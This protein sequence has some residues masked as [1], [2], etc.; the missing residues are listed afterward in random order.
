[1]LVAAAALLLLPALPAVAETPGTSQARPANRPVRKAT[2]RAGRASAGAQ[3]KKKLRADLGQVRPDRSPLKAKVAT[4]D[5]A[6]ATKKGKLGRADIS[7]L[8]LSEQIALQIEELLRGPLRGGTTSLFVA[9]AMT[10]KPVFSVYPDDPLNPASNVKLIATATALDLLGP[11]YRYTTRVLGTTPDEQT[12]A[13]AEGLYLLGTYDPTFGKASVEGLARQLVDSGLRTLDGDIV[14]G[15]TPTRD[16]MYRSFVDLR[17][18]AGAP[19]EAPTIVMEPQTDFVKLVVTATTSK[20]KKRVRPGISVTS[21]YVTDE[22][23]HKRIQITVAGQ[24]AAG[25]SV[26]RDVWM[27][28]RAYFAAHLLR[29]ALRDL[30]VEVNGDVRVAELRDYL[31]Q[32]LVAG[33]I[34]VPIAEHRSQR[35]A[36]IVQRV[37]KRSTNWLADRVIMTAAA[38]RY[39]GKPDMKTAV[40]AMYKWL[41]KKA[42]LGREDVVIDTGSGLSYKTELSARQVVAV[43]RAG[44]GLE[45]ATLLR[46]QPVQDAYRRSL[47][48]GGVDGTIRKRFKTLDATVLGKTGTLA[49]VVSIAGVIDVDGRQ[50]VF[51]L[52]TNGHAPHWKGRVRDGHERLVGL[53]CEYLHK[54]PPEDSGLPAVAGDPVPAEPVH[55]ETPSIADEIELLDSDDEESTTESAD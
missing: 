40:E 52:I 46:D 43:L 39:G 9:D 48:I 49:R 30:G 53:L 5:Q 45:E 50:L 35:L 34:P 24:I 19:G 4:G 16:G 32:A 37:N 42:G 26:V 27:K 38:K 8:P 18:T 12:G 14:V 28:E 41:E 22:L 47:A 3:T 1:V 13:L 55:V 7:K 6:R 23:G 29:G 54:L 36:E 15:S 31:D 17:I 20:K 21:E 51:S 25:K 33:Y 11:D 44:L 2:G 10:G